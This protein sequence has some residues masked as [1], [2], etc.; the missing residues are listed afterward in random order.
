MTLEFTLNRA[1]PA[2][3]ATDCIVVGAYSDGS[4]TPAAQALDGEGRLAAL[5]GRGDISGATGRSLLVHDVPGIGAPRVL[6]IGLGDKAKFGVA[7]YLKAVADTVRALK[8]GPVKQALFTLS[9]LSVEGRDAAWNVRQA[10]VA[11][12]HA[13]YR[14]LA[15]LGAKNKK[16]SESGLSVLSIQGTDEQPLAQGKAIA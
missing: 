15:T 8:T 14:Y 7:Q 1:A 4:L 9:E 11:S 3:A 5:A 10:V 16:R 6:V 12:D 2:D 13:A